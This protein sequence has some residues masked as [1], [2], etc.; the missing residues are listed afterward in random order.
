MSCLQKLYI[1]AYHARSIMEHY[2]EQQQQQ[3][4]RVS[5]GFACRQKK[6]NAGAG[7]KRDF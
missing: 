7:A 4:Y 3:Q 5:G 2:G 1:L 6:K